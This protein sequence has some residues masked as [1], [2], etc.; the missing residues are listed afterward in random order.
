MAIPSAYTAHLY[1]EHKKT[2]K[3][4]EAHRDAIKDLPEGYE[5]PKVKPAKVVEP[6]AEPVVEKKKVVA[7]MLAPIQEERTVIVSSAKKI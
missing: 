1:I 7:P 6:K 5:T 3:D 4:F 2:D